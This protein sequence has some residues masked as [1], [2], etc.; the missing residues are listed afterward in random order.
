LPIKQLVPGDLIVLSA[1][2]MIPADCR[3]LSAKDLFVS[4]AAEMPG[5]VPGPQEAGKE[6]FQ[7]SQVHGVTPARGRNR[8]AGTAVCTAPVL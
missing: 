2:D 8:R 6:L 4:Q 7:Q 5:D 3:V 1:G